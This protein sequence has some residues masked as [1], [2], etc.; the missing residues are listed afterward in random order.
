M[1]THQQ[2]DQ[3]SVRLERRL[4]Q[5]RGL[6][7][8]ELVLAL[9]L[10]LCVMALIVN[11]A[12]A[13]TWKIRSVTNARL[14]MWRHRPMWAAD[15]DPRPADFW[16]QTASMTVIGDSRIPQVDPMWNQSPIAQG[17]IKGPSFMAELGHLGVRDNRVNEMGEGISKGVGTVSLRYPFLPAMGKMTVRAEQALL[18]NVWQ[19]HSMGYAWN[20]TRRAKAWWEFDQPPEAPPP[21]FGRPRSGPPLFDSR[22]AKGW[23]QLED[24]RAWSLLKRTFLFDDQQMQNNPMRESVR[25]LDRDPDL[26]KRSSQ[27]DFYP[28]LTPICSNIPAEVQ[29]ELTR[30]GGFLDEF[31]N[32]NRNM[33]EAYLRMYYGMLAQQL[34]NPNGED[35]PS[36][37]QLTEWIAELEDFISK[38][39]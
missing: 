12:H 21:K 35:L 3:R 37:A 26:L 11:F 14:A 36:I 2:A 33:A 18:D 34:A 31:R 1:K 29:F 28:K 7:P 16:P 24:D 27:F 10:L 30:P 5:R 17:W 20:E 39:H 23:W 25:P 19:Y 22:R 13:A 32:V 38:L 8:L 6:A 4:V 15:W 9:P